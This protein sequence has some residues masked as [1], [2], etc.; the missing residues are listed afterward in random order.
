MG[1]ETPRRLPSRG[2]RGRRFHGRHRRAD[3][4]RMVAGAQGVMTD[5][6]SDVASVAILVVG[7]IVLALIFFAAATHRWQPEPTIS[8]EPSPL[9]VPAS[10]PISSAMP[11]F[12]TGRG[13]T[14]GPP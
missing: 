6:H 8:A 10:T 9:A 4:A 7:A 5:P 11:P 14:K 12:G 1:D 2:T 13:T 3:T